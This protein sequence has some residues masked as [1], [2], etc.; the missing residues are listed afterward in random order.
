MY[1]GG[2]HLHMLTSRAVWCI[3]QDAQQLST[4]K[5]VIRGHL[6]MDYN[7]T[8]PVGVPLYSANDHAN[9]C[10]KMFIAQHQNAAF[11]PDLLT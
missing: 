2:A 1:L 4:V 5:M 11:L 8:A 10:W 3:R 9:D 7:I 6:C